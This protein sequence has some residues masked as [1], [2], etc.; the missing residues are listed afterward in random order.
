[1]APGGDSL[2]LLTGHP[3]REAHVRHEEVTTGPVDLASGA[4]TRP[5]GSDRWLSK[6]R[7]G[8][9]PDVAGKSHSVPAWG[10]AIVMV[11]HAEGEFVYPSAADGAPT[12]GTDGSH[13]RV[14]C[15]KSCWPPTT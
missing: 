3:R 1:M 9:I 15:V 5:D 13:L 10:R 4:L 8:S 11:V 14:S 7:L 6:G 2:S 12:G